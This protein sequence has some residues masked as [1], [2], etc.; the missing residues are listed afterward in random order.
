MAGTIEQE[1]LDIDWT[2][3]PLHTTTRIKKVHIEEIREAL[4]RLASET[5]C[6]AYFSGAETSHLHGDN[7]SHQ[8]T[9][10]NN[11]H[12]AEDSDYKS[13]VLNSKDTSALTSHLHVHRSTHYSTHNPNYDNG[14]DST[15]RA[16]YDQ[17][18]NRQ[19]LYAVTICR[20]HYQSDR[21][22][23]YTGYHSTK[24]VSHLTNQY[25]AETWPCVKYFSGHDYG[26][27]SQFK[28]WEAVTLRVSHQSSHNV[29]V[30][31][32]EHSTHTCDTDTS[33]PNAV[34]QTYNHYVGSVER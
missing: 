7:A 32:S 28:G 19:H 9:V 34:C 22:S 21:A 31:G 15:E 8:S 18:V 13:D 25:H 26:Y 14:V 30:Y 12:T 11:Y 16:N 3:E 29:T 27:W 4:E 10:L 23:K 2:D 20:Y 1:F 6:V 33:T 24:D 5:G 17:T